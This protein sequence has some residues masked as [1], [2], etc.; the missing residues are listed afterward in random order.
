[1]SRHL[2]CFIFLQGKLP[3]AFYRI[4]DPEARRFLGRCLETASRRPS[5]KELLLDPFLASDDH[6]NPVPLQKYAPRIKVIKDA[7]LEARDHHAPEIYSPKTTK[8]RTDMTITGKL[9]PEDDT[10]FLKVQIADKEGKDFFFF[11]L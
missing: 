10:I 9:N 8:K 7:G 6:H 5:A 1:M 2:H 4:Q 11:F 3:D